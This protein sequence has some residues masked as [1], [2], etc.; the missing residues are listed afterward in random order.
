LD[1]SRG[2]L[3]ALKEKESM[4]ESELKERLAKLAN[5]SVEIDLSRGK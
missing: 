1:Q 5:R 3:A 2:S 4:K